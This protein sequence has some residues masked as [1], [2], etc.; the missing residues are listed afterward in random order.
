MHFKAKLD[1]WIGLSYHH[2][3]HE[4]K[5][6]KSRRLS[7]YSIIYSI[8]ILLVFVTTTAIIVTFTVV[9][10]VFGS[11]QIDRFGI[12]ELYPSATN[13]TEWY[14]VWDNGYT[15]TIGSGQRDPYDNNFEVTGNG[16]VTIDGEDEGITTITGGDPRMRVP[17]IDFE[18]VE[19]TFYAKRISEEE[20]MSYQGF[21]DGARSKHYTNDLCGANTYYGRFTYDGRVSFEKELFYGHGNDA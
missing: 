11:A 10:P 8:T 6:I 7:D 20:E 19:I 1:H 14:S 15:R 2:Y 21:V 5:R 12:S 17:D 9:P 16:E 4:T 13:G 3:M 18:N